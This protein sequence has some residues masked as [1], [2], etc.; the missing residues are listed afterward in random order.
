MTASEVLGNDTAYHFTNEQET[1]SEHLTRETIQ[2]YYGKVLQTKHDLKT[3]ACCTSDAMPEH[4]RQILSTVHP[5]VKEKF[6]GCGSP[7][8]PALEG[9]TV[10]DL[11]SGSGRDCFIL[12]KLVGPEG[13]VIGVDM[14]EEQ[15]AVA[16]RHIEYHT[17]RF[18]YRE[19]N[20]QFLEGYIEDLESLGVASETIDVVVSNCVINLS[21][22]KRRVFSEILRVLKPGGELYACDVFADRRI[23]PR[24]AQDPVLLGECLGGALY[25]EDFRRLLMQLGCPDYRVVNTTPISLN[26]PEVEQK[27]G[28]IGF[29]SMT[30][31]AFKLE[32]EDRCEDY[33]QAACYLGTLAGQP[34]AF[35]L[36]NHHLFKTGKPMLVCSNTA[37]M[38]T[39]T[40]Y[41]DHFKVLGDQSTHYGLFDCGPR[42]PLQTSTQ[43]DSSGACC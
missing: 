39:Q 8:P 27:A 4:L 41:A 14:T 5:E 36:D 13:R 2:D 28:M 25:I 3:S 30:I 11:G 32:L 1:M 29:Y 22:D 31:R 17:D 38:L 15:L 20:V 33:G 18:G 9:K 19:P 42:S 43:V 21:P 6:Y 7:I 34:H 10:L 24:L 26:D 23:P 12:S 16:N 35:A 37:A 40:R